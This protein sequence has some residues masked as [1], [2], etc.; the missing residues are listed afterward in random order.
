MN[1]LYT[2]LNLTDLLSLFSCIETSL[3]VSTFYTSL[4]F[5]ETTMAIIYIKEYTAASLYFTTSSTLAVLA[6]IKKYLWSKYNFFTC[7]SVVTFTYLL[8]FVNKDA[9]ISVILEFLEVLFL[10]YMLF[11]LRN[12]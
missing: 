5:K 4:Y 8:P 10:V 6:T 1:S 2:V 11:E 3:K 7:G 12:C 9:N